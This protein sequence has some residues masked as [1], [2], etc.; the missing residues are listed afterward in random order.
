MCAPGSLSYQDGISLPKQRVMADFAIVV[1]AWIA[2][3]GTTRQWPELTSWKYLC[4]RVLKTG[5]FEDD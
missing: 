5:V 2:Q 1:A 4:V 3:S